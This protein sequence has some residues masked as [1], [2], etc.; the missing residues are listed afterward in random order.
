MNNPT[1]EKLEQELIAIETKMQDPEVLKNQRDLRSIVNRKDEIEPAVLLYRELK[2]VSK[3]KQ[4]AHNILNTEQDTGMI[5][6]AKDE[7]SSL[8]ERETILQE[9]IKVALLPQDPNDAKNIIL[10]IRPAAGG[11]EASLF[12]AE[13]SRMYMRFAEN[14]R[15]KVEILSQSETESGGIKEL[16]LSVAG[17]NVYS[18]LK[19]ESGVHR[20]QRIPVTEAKGR[21]HTSTVTVAVLPEVDE[22]DIEIRDE[23]LE[24]TTSRSSGAGG[25]KVNKT[26]SAV[27]MVHK[28]SGLVVEC[29]DERSQLQNKQKALILMRAKLYEMEEMKRMK[30]LGEK[31]LSQVGTGDRSEK[32]RTYNFPQDRLTDHRVHKNWSNLPGI[33]EGNIEDIVSDM[34]L[35]DQ[36]RKLAESGL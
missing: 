23:D 25:Q 22:V 21:V 36:A 26:S 19:F 20:V 14:L 1:L 32:I 11:D 13:L 24:I 5:Q 2:Q 6:L 17:K 16:V 28:P 8:E 31:R 4:E 29:Q 9:K 35:E 34:I 18:K 12:A 7:L 30:E 10:E 27:R 33:M 3:D 15:W